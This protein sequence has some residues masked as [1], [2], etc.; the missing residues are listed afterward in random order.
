MRIGSRAW[1]AAATFVACSG[2][3][4]REA[5]SLLAAVDRYR[6]ADNSSKAAESQIVAGVACSDAKVCG[7][8]RACLD[9]IEPTARALNLKD[10]VAR[11]LADIQGKRLTPDSSEAQALPGKLDEAEK[12]L[13]EG[14]SKMPDC[15]RKLTDLQI[16]Y[17]Y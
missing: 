5:S 2:G 12:L 10:E 15:E 9:A 17:G 8:K 7:A 4:K 6:R 14:R 1:I 16:E 3:A 13:H 11:R